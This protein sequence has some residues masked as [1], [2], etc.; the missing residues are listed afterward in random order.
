[1]ARAKPTATAAWCRQR[2]EWT[3]W[4]LVPRIADLCKRGM[5]VASFSPM[6][7]PMK[8]KI[9]SF[10]CVSALYLG[11]STPVLAAQPDEA[12]FDAVLGRPVGFA[13]TII[14]GAMF[15][16]SLPV[17]ATSG[18]IKSTA[19]ALVGKPARFTFSRPLGD[20]GYP[21]QRNPDHYAAGKKSSKTAQTQASSQS[22][23]ASNSR[24]NK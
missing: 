3:F 6:K 4:P 2:E 15:V 13:A 23:L 11:T 22:E 7:L 18:S 20:F 17:A 24:I 10:L 21:H 12:F 16:V 1:M 9:L 19:H 8:T 5:R 14:G